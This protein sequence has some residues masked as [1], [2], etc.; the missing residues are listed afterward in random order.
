MLLKSA[1]LGCSCYV[2]ICSSLVM[3]DKS[4]IL[5]SCYCSCYYQYIGIVNVCVVRTHVIVK[6]VTS[7]PASMLYDAL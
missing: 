6:A 1:L 2:N 5:L 3:Y 7:A 4:I